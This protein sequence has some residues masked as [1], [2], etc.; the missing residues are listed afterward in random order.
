MLSGVWIVVVQGASIFGG[1]SD[2][3][4]HPSPDMPGVKRLFLKGAAVFGGVAVKN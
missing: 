2:E 4:V 1:F 3:S